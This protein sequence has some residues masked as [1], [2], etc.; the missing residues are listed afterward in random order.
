MA[1]RLT[2]LLNGSAVALALGVASRTGLLRALSQ[3]RSSGACPAGDR[4]GR[5]LELVV[6]G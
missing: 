4:W 3:A 1:A 5:W 2:E 6:T